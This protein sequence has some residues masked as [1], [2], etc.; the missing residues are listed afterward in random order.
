MRMNTETFK[1]SIIFILFGRNLWLYYVINASRLLQMQG[2][3][4]LYD[5]LYINCIK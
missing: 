3:K 4:I 5:F 2:M 1:K